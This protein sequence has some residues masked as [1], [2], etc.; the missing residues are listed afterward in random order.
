MSEHRRKPPQPQGGG[1]AAARR[2]AQQPSGRRAAPPHSSTGSEDAPHSEERPY[3]G[4]AEARR[5]AQRGGR[6]RAAEP[7]AAGGAGHGSAGHGGGRRGGGGGRG[8][9]ADDGRPPKKKRFIDYPRAGKRGFRRWVPS[10][11]LVS[12]TFL[13]FIAL[14]VGAVAIGLMI[15]KV[16]IPAEA[17]KVQKNVYY[18]SNGEQMVVAGGGDYNRQIVPLSKIHKSM[19]NAVIAAENASFYD[20]AGVDP[21][22]IARAVVNMA[23][24]GATQSGSTITQQYVK[25]TYLGQEQT[26][27]RKVTELFIS[28]KVGATQDKDD[29][30]AGYLNTAYYGRGAYGIQAAARA[31]YGTDS[32]KLTPSQSAFLAATLN[33]PNLYDP[34][35]GIGS[36]ATAEKNLERAKN[37]WEWILKREV[38]T[39]RMTDAE[40]DKWVAKG[41]PDP[42]RP[43]PATNKAGQIGY[44]TNLAD[45]YIIETTGISRGELHKGGYQIHTTFDKKKVQ[46]LSAAVEKV[47]KE[48]IK[49]KLRPD[50]DKYVQ[51]GGAS[52]EPGTGKIVA[53][54]GGEDALKHWNNNADYTGVQVG[55]TFK[56][57]VLAAAMTD[58]KRDPAQPAEQ[59]AS[60]R[61]KVSPDSI[62]NGDNK[63]TLREF[64]GSV[65]TDENGKEWHQKNDGNADYGPIDLRTAMQESANT[66]FIQLGMD[67]GVEKVRD[68]AVRAGLDKD[69]F[70]SLTP[71]FSLGT[72]APSAINLAG[73]YATFAA[74]GMQADP[75][76]VESIERNGVQIW[77]HKDNT[78][79]AFD[80]A[81]ADNVTDVL[82]TVVEEGTGKNAR[83]GRPAA[84]KTGTTDDNKSA[85]FSGYTPQLSTAIGMWRIDD[86]AKGADKK[87]LPMYGVGGE[88][89]IH[90]ASFPSEIWADYMKAAMEG[91]EAKSFPEPDPI[92]EDV[93]GNGASPDP[94]TAPPTQ[95]PTET[96]STKT[97]STTPSTKTPSTEPT[98][99]DSCDPLD[100]ECQ[101]ADGGQNGGPGGGDPGGHNGGPGGG[102]GGDETEEPTT[103]PPTD[104]SGGWFGA[105][106]GYRRE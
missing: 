8:K 104:D 6:R 38:E 45:E 26:L 86:Q 55:S 66:P 101:G 75:Y 25:N 33:G 39:D 99:T 37:R 34:A 50:T 19:Q 42:Q 98:P 4:R 43:K 64:D 18:W 91:K 14:L 48:N 5:A 106:A 41:F 83:I 62:Y 84:G 103:E 92:G 76:S 7:G 28:I 94:T 20:D 95:K 22:G 80:T 88:A 105:P 11:K 36:A 40:R 9:G 73:G 60:S 49:P 13:F 16:P 21:M 68:A 72:S 58:G 90:G 17:A 52:V 102:P 56:P 35:G 12:G 27:K 59:P 30:L 93:Y 77:K 51:F 44:L 71:T 47:T 87:F 69:E 24:G 74:R 46:Q 1:R 10:W 97:P 82:K 53:V 15:V 29:I 32:D 96:P 79:R 54:Y 63:L 81:V 31:Y 65:W 3:G 89:T 100:L 67:V 85:W 23:K 70:T 78:E 57:F 2:A 61:T